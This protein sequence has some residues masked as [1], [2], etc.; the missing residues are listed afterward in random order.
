MGKLY[1]QKT[2]LSGFGG[3]SCEL[4]SEEHEGASWGD[5]NTLCPNCTACYMTAYVF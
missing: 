5:E 4:I 3:R 2:E 1:G